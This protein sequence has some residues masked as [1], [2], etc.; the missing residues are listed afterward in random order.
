VE[1]ERK[2]EME[3]EKKMEKE[4]EKEMDKEEEDRYILPLVKAVPLMYLNH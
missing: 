2:Q 4:V 1:R 3:M